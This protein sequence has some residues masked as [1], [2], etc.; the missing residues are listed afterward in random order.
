MFTTIIPTYERA[1]LLAR[2]IQSALDQTAGDTRVAV[3]DNA[4]KDE[5][6]ALVRATSEREPR[7]SYYR[8]PRNIGGAANI[9]FAM[10]RVATP[11]FS[12]LCDD[13]ILLPRFYEIALRE[14]QRFPTAMFVGASTL[15]ISQDGKL[16]FAPAAFWDRV[17]LFEPEDALRRMTDGKHP[18]MTTVAFRREL[19]DDIGTIDPDAGTLLDLDFYIRACREHPCAITREVAGFFVRHGG[20]WSELTTSVDAEY[21]H[22]IEKLAS[23]PWLQTALRRRRDVRL[24]QQGVISLSRNDDAKALACARSLAQHNGH[25]GARTILALAELSRFSPAVPWL[26]RRLIAVRLRLL[27]RECLSRLRRLGERGANDAFREE[28]QYF[29]NL[30]ADGGATPLAPSGQ[31]RS[32]ATQRPP[33]R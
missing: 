15:E 14:F 27:G 12:I 11:F 4:S 24:L 17:G 7:V 6:E 8:H 30:N 28:L 33:A 5:T 20:T 10:R 25:G 3:Y 16:F 21:E 32:E 13:D 1:T 29:K 9:A 23:E 31:A 19:V 2:A 26:I 18:T 22:L